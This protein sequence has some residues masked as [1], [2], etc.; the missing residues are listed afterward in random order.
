[1]A[2]VELRPATVEDRDLLERVYA[3][4]RARELALV[5]W[6]DEQKRAFVRFQFEAQSTDYASNYPDASFDVVL[7]DGA[8]AGRLYVE[9]RPRENRI[10]DIA[11]LPEFRGRGVGTRL[12][13][14]V[15]DESAAA[16]SAVTIHVER[17][18]PA[19]TLYGRLGFQV[20]ADDGGVYMLM[21]W[22]QHT[23]APV[24]ANTAS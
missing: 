14:A 11:L 5:P 10:I 8:P 3:S 19:Q 2:R 9:R 24:Q 1:M 18:N 16:G 6:S 17:D 7:V 15:L 22:R 21:E 12:L 23:G 4:T 20:A 13:Q